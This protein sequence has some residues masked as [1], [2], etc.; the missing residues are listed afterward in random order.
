MNGKTR[1]AKERHVI[2]YLSSEQG[3]YNSNTTKS[4][5]TVHHSAALSKCV[6]AIIS[7]IVIVTIIRSGIICGRCISRVRQAVEIKVC[8][9]RIVASKIC[10]TF[11]TILIGV[12]GVIVMNF[13][14]RVRAS[15]TVAIHIHDSSGRFIGIIIGFNISVSSIFSTI[16]SVSIITITTISSTISTAV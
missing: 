7:I 6:V 12:I 9:F 8:C 2:T 5:S 16:I 13:G 4:N 3:C 1:T 10:T 11:R 14:I 15:R